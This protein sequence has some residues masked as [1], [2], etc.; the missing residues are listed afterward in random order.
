MTESEL[1]IKVVKATKVK[2][3]FGD[4]CNSCGWCCLTEVCSVG[5]G[6]T[7]STKLPCKLLDTE[8]HL[9][10]V[11]AH[12]KKELAIGVGCDAMT[13]KELLNCK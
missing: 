4:P 3:K 7:G 9:C 10:T 13:Q 8:T 12:L 2:P 5:V 1:F 11:A 6:I